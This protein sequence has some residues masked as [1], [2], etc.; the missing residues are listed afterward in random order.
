MRC[1]PKNSL[2]AFKQS[3]FKLNLSCGRIAWWYLHRSMNAS[4]FWIP[5]S[6]LTG[7]W[8]TSRIK[9]DRI[10]WKRSSEITPASFNLLFLLLIFYGHPLLRWSYMET[11]LND[12]RWYHLF[13]KWIYLRLLSFYY[14]SWV[15]GWKGQHAIPFGCGCRD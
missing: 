14:V 11:G 1:S 8:E 13:Q 5:I 2:K 9:E 10:C 3:F 15:T 12:A 7:I 6:R 4:L